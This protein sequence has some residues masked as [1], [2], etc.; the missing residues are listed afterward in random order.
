MWYPFACSICEKRV[1]DHW[2]PECKVC[3]EGTRHVLCGEH[4]QLLCG[5]GII[6]EFRVQSDRDGNIL[7]VRRGEISICPTP[8]LVLSLRLMEK[9]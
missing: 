7:R 3:P 5:A 9:A 1:P 2:T 8:E 6:K 4:H